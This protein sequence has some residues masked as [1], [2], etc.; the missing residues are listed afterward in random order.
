MQRRRF[1][2]TLGAAPPATLAAQASLANETAS[3]P[4]G[5]ER[6]EPTVLLYD[7]G[8]HAAPLY[9]FAAPMAPQDLLATVDQLVASG[10]DTLV[11]LAGLEGGIALYDSK[12]SQT[13]GDNV[14]TWKHPVWYRAA[15]HIRQ[16]IDAGQDPLR[17]I[18][19]RCHEKGIWLIAGNYIGLEGST[20]EKDAGFGRKSD[21]VYDHPEFA[22]GKDSDP[23]AQG[24]APTR[25]SFLHEPLRAERMSVYAEL[26]HR[27]TTDGVEVNLTE[28]VP[29]CKFHEVRQLEKVLTAWLRELRA[30]ARRA[31]Q[32]QGRRKRIYVRI[33]AHPDAWTMMGYQVPVWIDQQLV[34]GLVCLP[35]LMESIMEQDFDLSAAVQLTRGSSC[36]VM[37]GMT[38]IVGRE[39]DL[40]ASQSMTWAAAANGYHQGADGFAMVTYCWIPNGWPWTAEDY[41]TVRP[42]GHPEMLANADKHYHVR[43]APNGSVGG[44]ADDEWLPGMP[45]SLPK[46]MHVGQPVDIGFSIA[47]DLSAAQEDGKLD[48][49]QLLVH[50]TNIE[51]SLNDVR[52]ELN[53]KVLPNEVLRLHDRIY[54]RHKLGGVGPY[55]Y[56]YEYRLNSELFPVLGANRLRVT[57]IKDD[58][59]INALIDVYDVD[60][61]IKYRVHRD[62]DANITEA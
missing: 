5:S 22:V 1:L 14:D 55:G 23:R 30:E 42:L 25:F 49:V 33:P 52:I 41:Q 24:L 57:L 37:A 32:E 53:G 8:R 27:Y 16:F 60:C 59:N 62:F 9:Q 50:L 56:I 7:D 21:F 11:Y 28:F 35:G 54:R 6:T 18:C 13:W 17:L 34:D 46:R 3:A 47:D 58:P 43:S 44:S 2:Q 15:R 51:P 31:E 26:L 61:V 38:P 12:V 36:R 29:F 20:R 45:A 19:D 40:N 10:V 48:S 4:T 39:F